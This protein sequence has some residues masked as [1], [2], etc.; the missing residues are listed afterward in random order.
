MSSFLRG[1]ACCCGL[2]LCKENWLDLTQG[3]ICY[4]R[5]SILKWILWGR[6]TLHVV[7][8]QSINE[9][10]NNMLFSAPTT[11]ITIL[12]YCFNCFILSIIFDYFTCVWMNLFFFISLFLMIYVQE[13][14]F[15]LF[16]IL[17]KAL[18][19]NVTFD[20]FLK[21]NVCCHDCFSHVL[22]FSGAGAVT[23]CASSSSQTPNWIS[24]VSRCGPN[25]IYCLPQENSCFY[26]ADK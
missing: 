26:L 19:I 23:E 16:F 11:E 5:K 24:D 13:I 3:S 14:T 1:W 15:K 25:N 2:A 8:N 18:K 6:N 12:I 22:W 21:Y 7:I 4:H 20:L 10:I 9:A 17:F